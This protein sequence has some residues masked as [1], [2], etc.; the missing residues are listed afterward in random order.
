L[1]NGAVQRPIRP[2][3]KSDGARARS[4]TLRPPM[5]LNRTRA[6]SRQRCTC[7]CVAVARARAPYIRTRNKSGSGGARAPPALC[8]RPPRGE[9]RSS[10]V[11]KPTARQPPR[12]GGGGGRGVG[13]RV[14][15]SREMCPWESVDG[16][17]KFLT[18]ISDARPRSRIWKGWKGRLRRAAT[19]PA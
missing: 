9:R 2:R 10:L 6:Q 18:L 13:R 7:V 15:N 8:A 4:R 14:G 12:G 11:Q 1:T 16:P 3:E 19:S 17:R 5:G